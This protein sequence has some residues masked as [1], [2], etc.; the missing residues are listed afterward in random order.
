M[1]NT[2]LFPF[3]FK[4]A[5]LIIFLVSLTLYVL[6]E[7][8]NFNLPLLQTGPVDTDLLKGQFADHNLTNEVIGLGLL[9]GLILISFASERHEDERTQLIRLQSL[10]ISHYLNY[11]FFVLMLF[12]INGLTFLAIMIYLPY[13]FLITFIAVYYLRLHL[14]PK[15]ATHE[16]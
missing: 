10:Q 8:Y 5:G 7:H 4:F 6:W 12:T 16:K 9:V 15:F 3:R 13:A 11:F 2:L 14:L 1:K